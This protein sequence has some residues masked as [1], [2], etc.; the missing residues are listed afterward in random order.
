MGDAGGIV[1]GPASRCPLMAR[2]AGGGWRS[3]HTHV[4]CSIGSGVW[5]LND[6]SW[7]HDD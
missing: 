6:V 1:P 4:G 7:N 3:R 2:A 5:E